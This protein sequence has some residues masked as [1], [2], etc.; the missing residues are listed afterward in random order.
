MS[1]EEILPSDELEAYALAQLTHET[2]HLNIAERL[3]Q[4]V[5]SYMNSAHL[6]ARESIPQRWKS[7]AA[8]LSTVAH[9]R[10]GEPVHLP[11]VY[12]GNPHAPVL[13]AKGHA[14]LAEQHARM[15]SLFES[16]QLGQLKRRRAMTVP[17][18]SEGFDAQ[19]VSRIM[20]FWKHRSLESLNANEHCPTCWTTMPTTPYDMFDD[21][22]PML[23]LVAWP[24]DDWPAD[25][26]EQAV[27]LMPWHVIPWDKHSA[28]QIRAKPIADRPATLCPEDCVLIATLQREFRSQLRQDPT[29]AWY[30]AQSAAQA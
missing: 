4:Q 15:V 20:S 25:Q 17:P 27:R 11:R 22:V 16:R 10:A 7:I 26:D 5:M 23:S 6:E 21:G 19:T 8:H 30:V 24:A 18:L 28:R 9:I 3:Q 13:T 14:L 12:V 2:V 29:S 1:R